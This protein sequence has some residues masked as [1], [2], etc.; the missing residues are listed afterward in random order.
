M[1]CKNCQTPLEGQYCYNC[2]QK[3]ISER[4]SL[5]KI[6]RDLFQTIVNLEKGFW[7]TMKELFLRPD[8]VIKAYLGG[9]TIK[10]YNPFRYYLIIIAVV[11]LL[12]VSLGIYDLQQSDLRETLSPDVPEH[13]RQTQ[14][15]I[16]EY[17][18]KFL[19]FIPLIILPFI[20]KMFHWI[21]KKRSWNYAEHLIST[22][23]LYGQVSIISILVLPCLYF[24]PQYIGWAFPISI[25][26]PALF[27]SYAYRRIF[28]ISTIKAFF[29][30]FLAIL[31]GILMMTL[32][33]MILTFVVI[34]TIKIV[35]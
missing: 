3:K 22:T 17:A 10:Y 12:N 29:L 19:N 8:Q 16:S 21:F 32:T 31:G 23:Y 14:I 18:K 24:A 33:I 35:G 9:A 11:A 25:L 26:I 4:F 27:F 1:E 34:I 13:I 6:L 15:A 5:K 28:E 20:A 7:Y 30:G 2:G